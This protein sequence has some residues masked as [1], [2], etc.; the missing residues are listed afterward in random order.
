MQGTKENKMGY[1]PV[2]KLLLTMSVPIMISMIV[3]ALYNIVDSIYVAQLSENALSAVSLAFPVQN[4][5]IAVATGTGVGVSAILSRA[6]GAG[7]KERANRAAGNSML[8]IV[9]S[10]VVIAVVGMLISRPII[11]GQIKGGEGAAEIVEMGTTYLKIVTVASLGVFG[12]IAFERLLQST[13]KTVLSMIVQLIGAITNIIL[14]PILIFGRYGFP[15][16]G[17]AGAAWATVTGQVVAMIIAVILHFALN[18]DLRVKLR[19]FIPDFKIIGKIYVIGIPSI[20]MV[21]I[22]SVMNFLLNKILS[23]L[24]ITAVAVFGAYFKMQSFV[25]MPVFGLNNGMVPILAYNY[26]ALQM[27]RI[28]KTIRLSMIYAVC[29]MLLGFAAFQ[30]FPDTLLGFFEATGDMYEIGIVALRILCF[31]FITAGMSVVCSSVYQAFGKSIYSFIVSFAR[32]LVLLIPIAFLLSLTGKINLVWLAFPVSEALC[33][34]LC[35]IF[36][37]RILKTVKKTIDSKKEAVVE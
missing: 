27:E 30:L 3:Q 13:G 5:M 4:L 16:L 18:K 33:W 11:A 37:K 29:I 36:L 32:Q 20:L 7:D 6:L 26:G 10:W 12:E 28:K 31:S 21:A 25:F 15:E 24:N 19:H 22:G 17:V 34:V 2:N 14:D 35:M 23:G 1:M 8:L 9:F